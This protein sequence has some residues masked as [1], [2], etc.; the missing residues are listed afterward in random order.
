MIIWL[1]HNVFRLYE[2]IIIAR[3]VISWVSPDSLNPVVLWIHR[4]TEPVLTPFRRIIP[5]ER[6]GLDL[7]P[8][9]VLLLMVIAERLLLQIVY[10][11]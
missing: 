4:L 5:T 7:S 2:L 11:F 8:L 9:I 1:I 6:F 10:I 3:V